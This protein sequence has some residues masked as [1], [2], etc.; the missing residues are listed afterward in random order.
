MTIGASFAQELMAE[1]ATTRRVLERVPE[2]RLTWRP[3]PK[4]MSLGQL[5]MHVATLPRQ[6]VGFVSGD[7]LDVSVAASG[8]PEGASRAELLGALDKSLSAATAYFEALLDDRAVH[9]WSL[10]SGSQTL[11]E[12]PRAGALRSLLFNHWYHHRGQL[13]VYLRLLDVPL[14]SVYGPT[15]DENPF[16][17]I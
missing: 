8:T 15:A 3:H 17:A 2:D 1:T 6:V 9:M 14:P 4:S 5:A 11:L 13:T 10:K 12:I 7:D 16:Q